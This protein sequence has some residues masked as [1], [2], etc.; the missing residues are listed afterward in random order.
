MSCISQDNFFAMGK[1]NSQLG[2]VFDTP[3]AL[4]HQEL[5]QVLTV[6]MQDPAVSWV[7][8]EG[9]MVFYDERLLGLCDVPI[10]LEV[11]MDLALK[12]RM[13]TKKVERTYFDQFIWPNHTNYQRLVF[14]RLGAKQQI[15]IVDGTQKFSSVLAAA[16]PLLSQLGGPAVDAALVAAAF[17]RAMADQHLVTPALCAYP[18]CEH[19]ANADPSIAAGF[20]CEKCQGRFN[21]DEWAMTKRKHTANCT[22]KQVT[23]VAGRFLLVAGGYGP[24]LSG[25]KCAHPNCNYMKHSDPTV[26]RLYC[27]EKCDGLHNGEPWAAGGKRHYASCQKIDFNDGGNLGMGKGKGKS[28]PSLL[29]L[30]PPSGAWACARA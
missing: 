1:I 19:P 10:W 21:G 9:F 5:L 26:S 24:A 2:G 3:E 16:I 25:I 8:L 12:R 22:S 13:K 28:G 30:R 17:A 29:V 4:N 14:S 7:L 18:D 23:V 11:P 20:C 27:C 15:G 6:E